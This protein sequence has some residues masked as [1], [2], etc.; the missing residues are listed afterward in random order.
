VSTVGF[1]GVGDMGGGIASRIIDAGFPTVLWARRAEALAEFTA[2]NVDIAKT[3]EE[4]AAAVDLV[5]VCVWSDDD[6]REV[7]AGERGVLSG[8]RPG[9]I[10]VVHS[11]VAPST[12]HELA[13]RA[14]AR[15]VVVLDAPVTGGRDIALAG[16]LTVAV[17]GDEHAFARCRPVFDTFATTVI[18]LGD[19][20]AGQVAKLLN[21]ALFAANMALADD[22]L[23]VG[24]ALGV[25]PVQLEEFLRHGSGRSYALDIVARCRTSDAIRQAALP[26]LEKDVQ[27]LEHAAG[28]PPAGDLLHDGATEA[29][30]RLHDPPA[31]WHDHDV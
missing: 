10:V 7:V 18:R 25:D 23:T 29:V 30:R 19:V 6:V 2:G 3:P 11:T 8:A 31:G 28:T 13:A 24:D 27:R 16:A 15:D 20:G 4:L 21:N 26:A 12:C 17:G 1:I 14:A 9:T 22:A 5:G